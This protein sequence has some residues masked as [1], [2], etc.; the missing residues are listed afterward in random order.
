MCALWLAFPRL[1]VVRYEDVGHLAFAHARQEGVRGCF[2]DGGGQEDHGASMFL[3]FYLSSE[4]DCP[5]VFL[6]RVLYVR[7]G[8]QTCLDAMGTRVLYLRSSYKVGTCL[9]RFEV[10][11]R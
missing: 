11:S 7:N 3:H 2:M 6:C 10:V 9:G 1:T 4:A 5:Q 8:P